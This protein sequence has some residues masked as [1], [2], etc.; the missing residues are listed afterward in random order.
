MLPI[1]PSFGSNLTSDDHGTKADASK[2]SASAQSAILW[3]TGVEVEA[4]AG[5]AADD[6]SRIVYNSAFVSELKPAELEGVLAHEV[7]HCALGHHCRRGEREPGLWN[8]AADLAINPIVLGN[9]LTSGRGAD[10][11]CIREPKRRRNLRPVTAEKKRGSERRT[12]ASAAADECWWGN[13]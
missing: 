6:G 12:A 11:S 1:L 8:E 10:R 5:F 9:G 13:G 2:N 3:N 4:R 7:L